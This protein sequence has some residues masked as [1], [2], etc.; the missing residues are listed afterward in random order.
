MLPWRWH[1]RAC[2][3]IPEEEGEKELYF[4]NLIS[5]AAQSPVITHSS[6]TRG[7]PVNTTSV[8]LSNAQSGQFFP[9]HHSWLASLESLKPRKKVVILTLSLIGSMKFVWQLCFVYPVKVNPTLKTQS[10]VTCLAEF[11]FPNLEQLT[12][13]TAKQ[14]NM[15]HS[16]S[17]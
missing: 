1:H 11:I 14:Q 8:Q 3:L 10:F 7:A 13:P 4:L 2:A 12:Q 17:P 5:P 15:Y 6:R 16:P 9:T